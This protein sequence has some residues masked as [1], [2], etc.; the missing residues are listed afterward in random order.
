MTKLSEI[1]T[2]TPISVQAK[3]NFELIDQL[4]TENEFHH[5]PVTDDAG[6]LIGILSK[7]DFLTLCDSMT[8]F[9]TER[10]NAKNQR[11]FPSILVEDIMHR[12]IATLSPEHTVMAAA[13]LFKEN[14]FHAI[15]V[16]DEESKLV[17][18]VTTFDLLN[19]AF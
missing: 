14:L 1:M 11:I 16:V 5:L 17:G 15:P 9:N 2:A 7:S 19:L 12:N 6:K 10:G 13:G 3:D 4:F 8:V 18:I